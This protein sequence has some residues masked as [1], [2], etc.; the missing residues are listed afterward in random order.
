[1][2]CLK[3][4]PREKKLENIKIDEIRVILKLHNTSGEVHLSQST[5]EDLSSASKRTV[6]NSKHRELQTK[7]R[8]IQEKCWCDKAE[9]IQL[10]ADKHESVLRVNVKRSQPDDCVPVKS[11]LLATFSPGQTP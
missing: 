7:L 9:E 3:Q 8:A 11:K 5:V 10:H 1:M 2:P 6:Y 4:D